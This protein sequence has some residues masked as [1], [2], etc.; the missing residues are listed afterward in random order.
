MEMMMDQEKQDDER[1]TGLEKKVDEGFAR[2]DEDIRELRGEMTGLR[3][4]MTGLRG[5][6]NTLRSEINSRLDGMQRVHYAGVVAIIAALIATGA[7]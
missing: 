6:M 7:F 5:E 1:L 4:E 2:I 3:G